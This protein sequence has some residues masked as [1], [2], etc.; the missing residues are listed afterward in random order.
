MNG[1]ERIGPQAMMGLREAAEAVGG[2]LRGA[3]VRFSGVTTDSRKVQP[4]DLFVALKGERF[5]GNAYVGE[6]ASH[7]AVAA[8]TTRLVEGALPMPQVVVADTESD[9]KAN[10]GSLWDTGKVASN[11]DA[12]AY[13]ENRATPGLNVALIR[14]A[15]DCRNASQDPSLLFADRLQLSSLIDI[16]ARLG[17]T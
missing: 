10:R 13:V 5:D 9:L 6:A 14:R 12:V 4:G 15:L 1:A 7:G 17:R 3:P 16:C 2:K 8:F 11:D